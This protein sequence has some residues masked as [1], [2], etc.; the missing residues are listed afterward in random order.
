M[1]PLT[2]RQLLGLGLGTAATA[3]AGCATPGTT[4]VN[5]QPTIPSAGAGQPVKLTYWAWLKDLQKVADIWNAKNPHVQVEAVWIPGG[6]QGGYQ[7]LYASLAAGGGPDLAQVE[8]RTIPEFLLVNGLTDLSRYGA[9]Q[10]ADRFDPTLWHQ[11]SFTGGTFGIPQDS[12]P[13]GTFY[14]VEPFARVGASPRPGWTWDEWADAAAELRRLDVYID[15]FPIAD[16]SVFAA[17][18]TQAGASWLTPTKDGWVIN[19]R[20]DATMAVARFFDRAI[21]RDLVTTAFT[22]YSP[23]WFAACANGKLASITDASWADALIQGV[24]GGKG[25][26]KVAPMPVWPHGG[27]GSSYRGGSTTAVLANSRHPREATEFAVW[28]NSS[29]EGIDGLIEHC[30]IGWSA[31]SD[32]IGAARQKPSPFFSGQDYN[33]DVFAPAVKQQNRHWSWWPVTQQ[34]F[35]ILSDEF[36]KRGAGQKLVDAVVRAEE[37]IIVAFKNKGLTIHRGRA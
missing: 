22:P 1:R 17:F 27:Y 24:T 8:F 26:W 29:R 12:G 18:A 23:G 25:K 31:S 33:R 9:R 37:Q 5:A 13:M 7:K 15:C 34:S 30:G 32:Y 21:E 28:L 10:Y 20:D 6:N 14:Q 11:A 3:L 19:M 4:S 16:A 35:N 36:R 2:R